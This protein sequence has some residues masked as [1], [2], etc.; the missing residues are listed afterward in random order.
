MIPHKSCHILWI[1]L[2]FFNVVFWASNDQ[3]DQTRLKDQRSLIEPNIAEHSLS[4]FKF[5]TQYRSAKDVSSTIL[6]DER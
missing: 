1:F 3:I 4:N 2:V 6:N 5:Q